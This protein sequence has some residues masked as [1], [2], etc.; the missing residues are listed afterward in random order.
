[1]QWNMHTWTYLLCKIRIVPKV[2]SEKSWGMCGEVKIKYL[3]PR[4]YWAVR[5][6]LKCNILSCCVDRFDSAPV[7]ALKLY[8]FPFSLL[9]IEDVR[10]QRKCPK[11]S[12]SIGRKFNYDLHGYSFIIFPSK[13]AA[14][15]LVR[16]PF[17]PFHPPRIVQLYPVKQPLVCKTWHVSQSGLLGQL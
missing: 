12:Y 7:H 13:C 14:A 4:W 16:C 2:H 17:P 1:M 3:S 15:C 8:P 6:S 9:I 10:V 11:L 5:R